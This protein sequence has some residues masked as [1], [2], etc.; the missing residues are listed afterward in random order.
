[1]AMPDT[2]V[3]SAKRILMGAAHGAWMAMIVGAVIGLLGWAAA[4]ALYSD[5]PALLATVTHTPVHEVWSL[6]LTWMAHWK[7]LLYGWLVF[8]SFLSC[9]WRAL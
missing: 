2:A 5:Y 7:L 1:M 8:A 6:T 9:W 3:L 4:V